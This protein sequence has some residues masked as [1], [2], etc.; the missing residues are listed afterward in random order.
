VFDWLVEIIQV[1]DASGKEAE[2]N[3]RLI[4]D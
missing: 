3:V 2:D 1:H 4:L